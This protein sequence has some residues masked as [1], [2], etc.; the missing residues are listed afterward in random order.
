MRRTSQL[1][2]VVTFV[3]CGVAQAGPILLASL[4]NT[5]VGTEPSILKEYHAADRLV[6]TFIGY[7]GEVDL[8]EGTGLLLILA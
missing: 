7:P 1:V 2:L 5:Y 8:F 4:S 6:Y 3:S